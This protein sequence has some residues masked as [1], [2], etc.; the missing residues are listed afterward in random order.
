MVLLRRNLSSHT[1]ECLRFRDYS[2]QQARG[3]VVNRPPEADAYKSIDVSKKCG[4]KVG[5]GVRVTYGNWFK[6]SIE[7][8]P[9]IPTPVNTTDDGRFIN[10]QDEFGLIGW[11]GGSVKK[12]KIVNHE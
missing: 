4:R 8:G 6:E 3:P 7:Y 11:F 5:S 1:S 10:E 2:Q 12:I 9:H